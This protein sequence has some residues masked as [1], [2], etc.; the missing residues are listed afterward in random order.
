[1]NYLNVLILTDL[2]GD[3]LFAEITKDNF[4]IVNLK[5]KIVEYFFP[6]ANEFTINDTCKMTE[7]RNMFYVP[8]TVADHFN[9]QF[10][11]TVH[12]SDKKKEL[13][14]SI[15][16]VEYDQVD[17]SGTIEGAVQDLAFYCDSE[18]NKTYNV[19]SDM[20]DSID[21]IKIETSYDFL[22][23]FLLFFLFSVF[24]FF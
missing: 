9:Q 22:F 2:I 20:G 23:F 11:G 12:N 21:E 4:F 17:F 16:L 14:D 13:L 8:Y 3:Q 5:D 15:S 19:I 24:C 10:N 18:N 6:Y 7:R 1:M